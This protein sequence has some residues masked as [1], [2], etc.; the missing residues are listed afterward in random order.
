MPGIVVRN[1]NK[2]LLHLLWKIDN[3]NRLDLYL[4]PPLRV[5][6]FEFQQ[7]LWHRKTG[8]AGYGVLCVILRLAVMVEVRLVT[9]G[10]TDRHRAIAYT[11]LA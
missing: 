11:A 7:D 8:V 10:R 9:D 4:A 3:S 1:V 5:T 6:P 2:L